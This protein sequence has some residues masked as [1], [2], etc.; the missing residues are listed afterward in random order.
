MLYGREAECALIE[1][2]LDGARE[3]RSGVLVLRGVAG[4]G[5][6]ALLEHARERANGMQVLGCRGVESEAELPFAA[7]HQLVRPVLDRV[8]VLPAP[9][10]TALRRALGL[11][12]GAGGDRFL[13]SVA[14]LGLLAE[15]AESHPLL[16][17]VDD[18]HWLDVA[19]AEAFVFVARRLEADPIVVLL[20][21][22][23][24]EARGF[25]APSLPSLRL[26]GL[27]SWG[28]TYRMFAS[29]ESLLAP[30]A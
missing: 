8:D 17:L 9:Q 28:L 18:A 19:S 22:R 3:S 26:E 14:L 6:S 12:A 10:A 2:L 5:K 1:E 13:V 27:V 20:A 30:R 24:G 29:L 11:D 15:A 23:E 4:V 25:E 7:V 16:C 21:V